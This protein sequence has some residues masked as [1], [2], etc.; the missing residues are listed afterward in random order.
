LQQLKGYSPSEHGLAWELINTSARLGTALGLA[1][2]VTIAAAR[3]NTLGAVGQP[4]DA[5]TVAGFQA[6]FGTAALLTAIGGL[7][8]F[9]LFPRPTIRSESV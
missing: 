5:A 8:A 3:T 9:M 2:R 6:A 1:S 7:A 4:A